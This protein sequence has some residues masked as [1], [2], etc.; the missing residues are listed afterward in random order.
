M[1]RFVVD[2]G[3]SWTHSLLT[4]W[5]KGIGTLTVE[6]APDWPECCGAK[7]V[8]PLRA[9]Y[10]QGKDAGSL[11]GTPSFAS[12]GN[13]LWT[14]HRTMANDWPQPDTEVD[15]PNAGFSMEWER[16]GDP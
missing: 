6:G 5:T 7:R 13:S 10:S 9:T 2:E 14:G 1:S 4:R 15:A 16:L 8:E 3:G 12:G 11:R